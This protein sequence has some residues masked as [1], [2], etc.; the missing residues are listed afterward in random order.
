MSGDPEQ[1]YFADGMAAGPSRCSWL[2]EAYSGHY[3]KGREL[4]GRE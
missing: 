3:T 2:F 4:L 1:E